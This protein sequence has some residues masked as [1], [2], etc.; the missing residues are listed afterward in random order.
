MLKERKR[1]RAENTWYRFDY[2]GPTADG[3]IKYIGDGKVDITDATHLQMY[4]AEYDVQLG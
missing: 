1:K 3:C 4:L 2:S